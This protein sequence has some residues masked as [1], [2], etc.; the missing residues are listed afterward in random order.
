MWHSVGLQRV[1]LRQT[2]LYRIE[3]ENIRGQYIQPRLFPRAHVIPGGRGEPGTER[4][5]G[6]FG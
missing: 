1:D 2:D 4:Y 5:N 6:F 3:A